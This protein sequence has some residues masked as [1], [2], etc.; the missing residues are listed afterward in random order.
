MVDAAFSSTVSLEAQLPVLRKLGRADR[1][2]SS[3]WCIRIPSLVELGHAE[4]VVE[5]FWVSH[6]AFLSMG[7]QLGWFGLFRLFLIVVGLEVP[8]R[9][10]REGVALVI[11]YVRDVQGIHGRLDA[12]L[13][14][15]AFVLG[16]DSLLHHLVI[17]S[18]END[19]EDLLAHEETFGHH[20]E[21]A[22]LCVEGQTI[23]VLEELLG[24]E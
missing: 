12:V 5:N 13:D 4:A 2:F 11:C 18:L 24:F 8:D 1:P 21:P 15:V 6:F 22:L 3:Q 16:I 7:V 9:V 14:A 20:F 19:L 23:L 10:I 17:E